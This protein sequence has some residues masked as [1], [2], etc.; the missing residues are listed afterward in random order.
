MN[1]MLYICLVK[2]SHCYVNVA[3]NKPAYQQNPFNPNDSTDTIP[4]VFTAVC[5]VH[6]QYVIYYNERLT[7]KTYPDNYRPTAEN[8]LCE[9]EVY[10]CPD[11]GCYGSTNTSLPCPDD[12]CHYCHKETGTCQVCHPGY[13]GQNCKLECNTGEY[14]INCS[15]SC[16]VDR[17]VRGQGVGGQRRVRRA[18]CMTRGRGLITR[19]SPGRGGRDQTPNRAEIATARVER[20]K[21]LKARSA[22]ITFLKKVCESCSLMSPKSI[23]L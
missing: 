23:Q 7:G 1:W 9:I 8:N 6:G 10:G 20:S 5:P 16:D 13:K 19:R 22:L 12:N 18:S 4:S 11:S 17:V 21:E 15:K 3:L 2:V 14:G